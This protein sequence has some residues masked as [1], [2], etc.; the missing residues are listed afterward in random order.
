MRLASKAWPALA[1]L[2][3]DAGLA[4]PA[5]AHDELQTRAPQRETNLVVYG[6]D[7]CPEP[8]DEEEIVVCARRPEQERYRVPAPLR[9]GE[10]LRET[11]WSSR[12][13]DL[14]EAQRDTRP[15]SCSVVGSFGQS[16]CTQQLLRA[17]RDQ[18]RGVR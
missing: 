18:R 5:A 8:A 12:A 14:E 16:G 4:A 3:F 6:E 7:P 9:R 1:I 13:A 10:Q 15:D 2:L 17:W 11:A